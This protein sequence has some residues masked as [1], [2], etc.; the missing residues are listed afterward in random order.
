MPLPPKEDENAP[1]LYLP[2]MGYVTYILAAGLALGTKGRFTPDTLATSGSSALAISMIEICALKLCFY[3]L[4]GARLPI[5]DLL[6]LSGYKFVGVTLAL[7]AYHFLGATVGWAAKV[8]PDPQ[9]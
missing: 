2:L 1:D 5:L 8:P 6:A 7:C 9:T 3:L 4:Q